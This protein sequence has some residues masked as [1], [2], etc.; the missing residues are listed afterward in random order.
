MLV[1]GAL[2]ASAGCGKSTSSSPRMSPAGG[3]SDA[4]AAGDATPAGGVNSTAGGD[5]GDV[6]S[7]GVAAGAGGGAPPAAAAAGQPAAGEAGSPPLA[8]PTLLLRSVTISQTLEL[9]LMQA[10]VAVAAAD[11]PAPLVANKRALLRAFV[12]LE[13]GFVARPLLGVLDLKTPERTRSL[14]S[15]ITVGQSSLQD[16]LTTTF[17]FNVDASDLKA[18][19]S[20]RVRVLE[21]DTTPIALFPD[22]DTGYLDLEAQT[23]PPFQLV[24]VPFVSNGFGP[25]VGDE[26]VAALERRLLALYPSTDFQVTEK[27]P[28]TLG[29]VVNAAGDGWD[30]ALDEIYQERATA[31]PAHDVFYFGM[32]APDTSYSSYCAS[33][34]ILGLSNIAD[35]G[36][37]DS[38]GSIGVTVFQDGSGTKVAWD[39]V[40]HELGHALGRDHAPCGLDDP[41]PNYPYPTGGLGG[42][43]GYDFDLLKLIKPKPY[44]DVMSYCT[45]VW[46]SDYTYRG[47]FERLDYIGS[48]AFRTLAF[49]PSEPF[50]LARIR[51]TGE[52]LWLGE[53]QRHGSAE[54]Q[55]IDLL[56]GAGQ[57]VAS[58]SAQVTHLDHAPGGYVW[59]PARELGQSGAAS[60]DLRPLGGS[61][62]PL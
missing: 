12:D 42:I 46:I 41:D 19:S 35:R 5:S 30:Q 17:V 58:V 52:S 9:P 43:Y 13:P 8:P 22:A 10:G 29:F 57:R 34:C 40:A 59:L 2:A 16:D 31:A 37:V 53:R 48:E 7:A 26:E 60:V 25:K 36:D 27:P 55:I 4:G 49:A 62:L 45:P 3:A 33:D 38:R 50:R 32:L 47:I 54:A 20:Y 18:A 11:R 23:L 1:L 21:E 56:D 24:L 44:R 61:V 15:K 28:V 51:R 14:V 6:P 39:T